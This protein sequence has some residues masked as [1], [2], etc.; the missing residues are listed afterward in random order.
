MKCKFASCLFGIFMLIINML[1]TTCTEIVITIHQGFV[2]YIPDP[3]TPVLSFEKERT[4]QH[5]QDKFFLWKRENCPAFSKLFFDC[6]RTT[7]QGSTYPT[8]TDC[9][10]LWKRERERERER[11]RT[12]QGSIYLIHP[13]TGSI[14]DHIQLSCYLQSEVWIWYSEI[15]SL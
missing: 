4:S 1:Y 8:H 13:P 12:N 6:L 11:E 5:C 10:F 15:F 9:F 3:L 7:D 2:I 14:I